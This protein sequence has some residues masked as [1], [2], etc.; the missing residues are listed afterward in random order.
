MVM[1]VGADSKA[2]QVKVETGI[3]QGEHVQITQGLKGGEM[4]VSS[5]A[6]GLPNETTVKIAEAAP[7]EGEKKT[8]SG[9]DNEKISA[10]DKKSAGKE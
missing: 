2:H 7:P 3:R 8:S 4:V 5:G 1:V 10:D 9:A 6:Y